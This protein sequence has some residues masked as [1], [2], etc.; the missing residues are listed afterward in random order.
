MNE[1]DEDNFLKLLSIGEDKID[2]LAPKNISK[3]FND[4]RLSQSEETG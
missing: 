2:Q 1:T 3:W 4:M